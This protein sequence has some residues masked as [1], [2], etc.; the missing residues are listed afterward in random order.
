M[1][2]SLLFNLSFIYFLNLNYS[3]ASEELD[4]QDESIYVITGCISGGT[5]LWVPGFIF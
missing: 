3:D 1:L 5:C 2:E 4:S